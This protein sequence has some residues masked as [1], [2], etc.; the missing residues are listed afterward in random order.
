MENK[1][2]KYWEIMPIY[3]M[4]SEIAI[5]GIPEISAGGS[6][7]YLWSYSR[8]LNMLEKITLDEMTYAANRCIL[9]GRNQGTQSNNKLS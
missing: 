8:E 4:I 6:N 9:S 1:L 3:D 7:G 2:I 5:S